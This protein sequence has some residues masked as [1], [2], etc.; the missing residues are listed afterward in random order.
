MDA[1]LERPYVDRERAG[2]FGYSYGGHMVA[3]MIGQTRRFK[4]AVCGAPSFDLSSQYCTSAGD[5]EY[6]D[7]GWGGAPWE[8]HGWYVSR[9]PSTFAYRSTTPTLILQGEADQDCPITQG[10]FLF[11]ILKQVGCDVEFA[12]YPEAHHGFVSPSGGYPEH[13]RDFL[14][15]TLDWFGRYLGPPE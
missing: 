15:R 11:T 2:I 5:H 1:V 6:G 3:W 12:R 10:E 14:Q 9:S 7:I 4:A 8:N 13:Q